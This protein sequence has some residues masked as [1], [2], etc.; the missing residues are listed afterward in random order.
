MKDINLP[1]ESCINGSAIRLLCPTS[2]F[3][4]IFDTIT[5]NTSYGNITSPVNKAAVAID[6]WSNYNFWLGLMLAILSTFLIGGSV[7]LKKKALLRLA[8][9]GE[10][11]AAEGGHGYLRD[12]LWWGGLLTMGGGEVANFA[13]Y[14]F[15]PATVV[16]PLGALSVL[17]SAVLSSH[18]FGETMNLLGKLGCL[19]S[20]LGSTIMVIHAPEEEEVTT[21]S[22]MTDKLLDPGFLVFACILLAACMFLIFYFSP[23]YGQTNILIYISIC[24][25]LGAFTVSSVKGLGIAVRTAFSDGSVFLHPLTWVLLL[26]L[27]GSIIIQINY[28]NKS[29]DTFNTLLVY[30]IYYV[31]FTTVVLS[32]SVILFKE[33]RAMSGVD[34]VGTLGGFL[35]IV[36]GVS[37]LH[38]FKDLN[39]CLEDLRNSLCE[40][41]GQESPSRR[42]DK[43]ILIENIETLPPM[44][45]EGP[46]VFIIS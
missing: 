2:T 27:I 1:I 45:E 22:E 21:L 30:P 11:R 39:V 5:G 25:L 17:I 26:T 13:A 31:F 10:M 7:T 42:E 20:I 28:L 41:L 8:S 4:C 18:L 43:H 34:V 35:V 40:P 46:R 3:V 6:K 44:R 9:A 36:I 37:M 38:L 14:M 24:S 33:W 12:W 16:T 32:T 29:L 19:L 15:A 23:R